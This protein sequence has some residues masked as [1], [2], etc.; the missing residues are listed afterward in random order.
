MSRKKRGSMP[1][2]DTLVGIANW[3]FRLVVIGF[4]TFLAGVA[5]LIRTMI[6]S[7]MAQSS[8]YVYFGLTTLVSLIILVWLNRV[9]RNAPRRIQGFLSRMGFYR[10]DNEEDPETLQAS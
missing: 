3:W 5:V 2:D 9:R 6:G 4:A 8:A 1:P 7:G 10:W